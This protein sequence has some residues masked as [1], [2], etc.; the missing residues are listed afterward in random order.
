MNE[1]I[2]ISWVI[3]HRWHIII[4]YGYKAGGLTPSNTVCHNYLIS[5][6]STLYAQ[7]ETHT[8]HFKTFSI[9]DLLI[10]DTHKNDRKFKQLTL[11]LRSSTF[12]FLQSACHSPLAIMVYCKT[13]IRTCFDIDEYND[14]CLG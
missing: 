11:L 8:R 14:I 12:H 9:P 1:S 7:K 10:Q 6:I 5:H 2:I 3:S 4:H 13:R